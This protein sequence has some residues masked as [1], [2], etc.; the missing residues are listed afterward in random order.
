MDTGN[1]Q[2]HA[3]ALSGYTYSALSLQGYRLPAYVY[4]KA[5]FLAGL[6][7]QI[8]FEAYDSANGNQ[9]FMQSDLTDSGTV[10][11]TPS[12]ANT[13]HPFN[14]LVRSGNLDDIFDLQM[15]GSNI[16]MPAN[17]T[18]AGRE[19]W[20]YNT[21]IADGIAGV[22]DDD[23]FTIYPNPTSDEINICTT[24][25][26]SGEQKISITNTEGQVVIQQTLSAEL[27]TVKLAPLTTGDYFVTLTENG[28]VVNTQELV[29]LK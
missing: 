25:Y 9:V 7:Q 15:W 8:F 16:I 18:D 10:A 29:V 20:I 2:I 12:G 13:N 26:G 27:T 28:R 17:F 21:G 14:S 24:P 5:A 1:N 23:L 4:Q 3:V 11:L 22:Q 19:L 6:G